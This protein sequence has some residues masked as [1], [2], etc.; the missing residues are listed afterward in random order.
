MRHFAVFFH[1]NTD[2]LYIEPCGDRR[3]VRLD[4]RLSL[5]TM[6]IVAEKIGYERGFD[7]YRIERGNNLLH[8][9]ALTAAIQ[10]LVKKGN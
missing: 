5:T 2:G 1:R 7:G 6:K 8:L 3:I 4:G 10:P 9:F